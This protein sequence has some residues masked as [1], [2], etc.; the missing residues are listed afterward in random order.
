[1]RYYEYKINYW[2]GDS[3]YLKLRIQDQA[4]PP[5]TV[6]ATSNGWS[7]VIKDVEYMG[8]TGESDFFPD[9]IVP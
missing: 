1:M 3:G 7:P 9:G 4:T 6:F 5:M 2:S 8:I